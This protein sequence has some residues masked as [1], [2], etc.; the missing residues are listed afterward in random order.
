MIAHHLQ[1]IIVVPRN[2]YANRLQAWASAAILGAELDVP[3]SVVWEPERIAPA[4]ADALFAP[5]RVTMSFIE[6]AE[7]TAVLGRAHTDLPRS[8][9]VDPDR[10]IVWLAG[11]DRGEQAFMEQL[12]WALADQ[13]RPHTLVIIAGG[14]FHVPDATAFE[15]QRQLFYGQ[16][17]WSE[18]IATR[19]SSLLADRGPYLGLHLRGTDRSRSAPTSRALHTAIDNLRYTTGLRALFIAADTAQTRHH[20]FTVAEQDGFA[21]WSSD[22]DAFDRTTEAAGLDALVDW[23]LLGHAWAI[24]YSAESSFAHEAAV[25]TGHRSECIALS[26]SA[27]RQRLRGV[28]DELVGLAGYPARRRARRG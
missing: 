5:H 28:R 19:V 2:G 1:R 24:A 21:P 11:H 3:V 26:A 6:A 17:E 13:S 12:G 18:P 8:L 16:L 4:S 22:S 25:A 23:I 9:H 15:R 10:R 20:W 27:G 14:H 7:L